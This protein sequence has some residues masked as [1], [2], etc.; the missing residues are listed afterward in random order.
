MDKEWNPLS[1]EN[2]ADYRNIP[3]GKYIFKVKALSTAN[4]WSETFEYPFIVHPPWWLRW[5]AYIF[6]AMVLIL[7]VRY[8]IRYRVSRERIK[9]EIQIK[10]VEVDK[11]QELDQMKSRFFANISHEFRTPLTL[12]PL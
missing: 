4:I 9:A 8:Y 3:S 10:Q 6:Y 12:I 7:L 1:T 2:K 11:M 5:W